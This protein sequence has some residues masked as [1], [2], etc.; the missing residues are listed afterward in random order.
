MIKIA[1]LDSSTSVIDCILTRKGRELLAKNDGSFQITKFSL[2]DDEIN[3]QLFDASNAD[4]PDA[5]ILNLPILEPVSNEDVALRYRLITLPKGS[6]KIA[7]LTLRPAKAT[8]NFGENVTFTVETV[9]GDDPQGYSA[10]VRDTDISVLDN[11]K[12]LP[13]E[14]GIATFTLKTGANASGK[15]G[16]TKVDIVGINSGGR[17][18]FELTVSASGS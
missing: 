16:V 3:Y 4:N 8:T 7:T 15:S 10:T 11:S 5:D 18:E 1:F 2:G 17:A 14:N 12:E 9:N 13:N 6:L